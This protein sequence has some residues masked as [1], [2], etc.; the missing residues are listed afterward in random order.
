MKTDDPVLK[1][2]GL[3]SK[4]QKMKYDRFISYYM[5]SC[6]ARESYA[7]VFKT[8]NDLTINKQAWLLVRHPY[9]V[10]QLR[11]KNK[12]MDEELGKKAVMNRERIL[13]ELEEI[14][15]KCKADK[16]YVTSLKALDQLAKVVGAYAPIK[17]E[18]T[19]N[20]IVINY[21]KPDND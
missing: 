11:E 12:A 19:H 9:V 4:S 17:E 5:I 18:V 1:R 16:N 8:T 10:M 3:A 20:G 21:I 13:T 2:F 7:K 14:L 6:N 15:D